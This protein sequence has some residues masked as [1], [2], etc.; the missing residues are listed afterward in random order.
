M[1]TISALIAASVAF[2]PGQEPESFCATPTFNSAG[3]STS[4]IEAPKH[5]EMTLA[6][7]KPD[8]V[9]ARHIGEIITKL[10]LAGF[11]IAAIKMVHMDQEQ[12]EEFYRPHQ[13]RPFFPSLVKF[14]TSG[15]VV[16][17]VLEGKD[18]I[19]LYRTM[20]GAT[21]SPALGTLRDTFA[22]SIEANAVHGSDSPE[23]SAREIPLLF[24]P[25]EIN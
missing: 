22:T 16:A 17:I 9:A 19:A 25:S 14:M 5:L 2:H 20:M 4:L 24:S 1:F 7:I 3:C 18:A 8:A 11:R 15:P 13:E 23:S 10:E 21:T 12:A 6:L